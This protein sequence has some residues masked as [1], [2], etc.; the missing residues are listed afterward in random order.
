MKYKC[1]NCDI[2]QVNKM[3]KWN[4]IGDLIGCHGCGPP[5]WLQHLRFLFWSTCLWPHPWFLCESEEIK[6]DIKRDLSILCDFLWTD[7]GWSFWPVPYKLAGTPCCSPTRW[8]ARWHEGTCRRTA[9]LSP[10]SSWCACSWSHSCLQKVH[11][12]FR[13]KASQGKTSSENEYFRVSV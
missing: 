8:G 13:E 2:L 1:Q 10:Q 11:P 4:C 5:P 7:G 12:W 9:P 3:D 6:I